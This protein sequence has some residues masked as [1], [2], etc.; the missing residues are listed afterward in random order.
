MTPMPEAGA[1]EA[2]IAHRRAL[3]PRRRG[4]GRRKGQAMVEF[5]LI[6]PAGFLLLL[7]ILVVGIIVT[8]YIQLANAA[9]DGARIAAICGSSSTAQMPDNSGSCTPAGVSAYI[10]SHLV[11]LPAGSVSP[12]IYFCTLDQVQQ[13]TCTTSTTN[14]CSSQVAAGATFCQ[15]QQGELLEVTMFYDQPLYLPLVGNFFQ[16]SP[17]NTR[18][19]TATAEATCEQ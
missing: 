6:A 11:A 18:R 13:N 9:R 4:L 2:P 7:S 5:A 10:T 17:N 1:Q 15:C 14:L 12:Q 3:S 19:L 16:T 8:N